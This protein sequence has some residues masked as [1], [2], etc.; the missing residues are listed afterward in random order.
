MG[1]LVPT[2]TYPA[3]VGQVLAKL[4]DE[5]GLTQAEFAAKMDLSPATWSKIESGTSGLSLEQL[6]RASEVLGRSPDEILA[7]A[8]RAAD[9]VKKQG[10][11]VEP[12]RVLSE[13]MVLIALVALAAFVAIVI[14][15][16]A[17]RA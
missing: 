4:R 16:N 3:I 8:Q 15:R 11:N 14:A 12:T 1:K 5:A 17:K 7:I 6:T 2:T 10:V 9:H 13:G